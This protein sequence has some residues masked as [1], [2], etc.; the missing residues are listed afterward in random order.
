M[1]GASA[2]R[3]VRL[4]TSPGPGDSGGGDSSGDESGQ[5]LRL[6]RAMNFPSAV[7]VDSLM[8]DV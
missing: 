3:A 1:H 5:R 2:N 8:S 6:A 7:A 4:C